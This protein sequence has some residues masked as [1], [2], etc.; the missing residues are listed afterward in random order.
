MFIINE[1]YSGF[2]EVKK[3]KFYSYLIPSNQKVEFLNHLK[4]IHPKATH[5]VSAFR[6]IDEINQILEYCDDDNEP[7]R[8]AGAPAMNVLRGADIINS[9]VFIVRYFG[10]IKLGIGGLVKAYSM[11]CNE[12]IKN[13]ILIHYEPKKRLEIKLDFNQFNKFQHFFNKNNI[14]FI[15]EFSV[16]GVEVEVFLSDDENV[17]FSEFCKKVN[18]IG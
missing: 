6:E 18:Y 4:T 5:I 14:K 1:Q 8:S 2:L 13:A 7:K 3:S 16:F 9:G 12:A 17:K 10:G 11:A 15:P